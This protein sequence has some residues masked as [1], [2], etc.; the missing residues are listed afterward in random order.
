MTRKRLFRRI[1]DCLDK[2][3]LPTT[4]ETQAVANVSVDCTLEYV[5]GFAIEVSEELTKNALY[6]EAMV[7]GTFIRKIKGLMGDGNV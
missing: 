3:E 1:R 7:A 5:L 6:S 4:T 2:T